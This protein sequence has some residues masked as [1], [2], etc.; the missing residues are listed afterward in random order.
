MMIYGCLCILY[1]SEREE[2]A[3]GTMGNYVVKYISY[4]AEDRI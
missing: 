4:R 2:I 1:M 3:G